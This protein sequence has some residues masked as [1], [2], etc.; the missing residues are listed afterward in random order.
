MEVKDKQKEKAKELYEV[1][2]LRLGLKNLPKL[3]QSQILIN[4]AEEIQHKICGISDTIKRDNYESI[5]NMDINIAKKDWLEIVGNGVKNK[6]LNSRNLE[7]KA[8]KIADQNIYTAKLKTSILENNIIGTKEDISTPDYKDN[9][10]ENASAK[11]N[12][13]FTEIYDSSVNKR[14]LINKKLYPE[15]RDIFWAWN[16]LWDF[17][18]EFEQFKILVDDQVYVNGGYP[19]PNT[20]PRTWSRIHNL[21]ILIRTMISVGK[22]NYI[23]EYLEKFGLKVEIDPNKSWKKWSN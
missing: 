1:Y 17:E 20:P 4:Y 6:Y 12:K 14:Y 19:S 7:E 13:E 11:E 16:Y 10:I 8:K 5:T 18:F 2:A 21:D 3:K 9:K 15:Y 22:E 23:K